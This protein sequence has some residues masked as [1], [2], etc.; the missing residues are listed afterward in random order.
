MI[1]KFGKYNGQNIESVD[2][3]YLSWIIDAKQKELTE[4]HKEFIRRNPNT[5]ATGWYQPV[6]P[7][8]QSASPSFW[9]P[10]DNDYKV[11][12]EANRL[13]EDVGR[14]T[15]GEPVERPEDLM[16]FSKKDIEALIAHSVT[17]GYNSAYSRLATNV[18][19]L[20]YAPAFKDELLASL[21]ENRPIDVTK[22]KDEQKT[23]EK[24]IGDNGSGEKKNKRPWYAE[25][26]RK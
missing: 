12:E 5:P 20:P 7:V 1:I 17:R 6:I 23:S 2:D 26:H 8:E 18:Q 11:Y 9:E 25:D 13:Y 24:P 14:K 3:N 15:P 16:T 21:I 22:F 10:T 4:F 19:A